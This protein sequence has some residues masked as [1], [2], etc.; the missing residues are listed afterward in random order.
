M[1]VLFLN[2][3]LLFSLAGFSQDLHWETDLENA[4]KIAKEENKNVLMYFTGSDWCAPCKALKKDF[5]YTEKF[6][7]QANKVVLLMIDLPF[8]DD[9]IT[10]EQRVKN[11]LVDK[12]YNTERS[13]PLLVA[14]N[15]EGTVL[16]SISAYS[17]F[18]TYHDTKEHFKF[19]ESI[20]K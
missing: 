3:C 9:I 4:K 1:K 20:V 6:A 11:K 13:Y 10:A 14:I 8:R 2:L 18:N 17:S 12:K 19:L 15:P 16:N 5:F 7:E